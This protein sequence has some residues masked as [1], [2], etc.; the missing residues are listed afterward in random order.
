MND[1]K[2]SNTVSLSE[3]ANLVRYTG[4]DVSYLF[5]GEMGI[6][7][8]YMLYELGKQ[9]PDYQCMYAEAPTFDKI[10]RAHV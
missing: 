2:P 3:A 4:Q 5:L 1:I 10:G 9:M 7:K 6:G 8:S